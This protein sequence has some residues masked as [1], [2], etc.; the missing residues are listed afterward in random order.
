MLTLAAVPGAIGSTGGTVPAADAA[1]SS[2]VNTPWICW[3]GAKLLSAISDYRGFLEMFKIAQALDLAKI[4]A[5]YK[6]EQKGK[7]IGKT[8]IYPGNI[9]GH[10]PVFTAKQAPAAAPK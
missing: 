5:C 7:R 9:Y 8:T 4:G 3:L 10:V 1:S 2:A 6:C